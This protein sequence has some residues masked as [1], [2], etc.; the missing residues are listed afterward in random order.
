MKG[1]RDENDLPP[2]KTIAWEKSWECARCRRRLEKPGRH[3]RP[4]S[5][6]PCFE[7]LRTMETYSDQSWYA[8]DDIPWRDGRY[9][10][11]YIEGKHIDG[12]MLVFTDGQCHW[13]TLWERFVVWLGLTDAELLQWKHRPNLCKAGNFKKPFKRVQFF[14]GPDY[15]TMRDR[16]CAGVYWGKLFTTFDNKEGYELYAHH[17]RFF[18]PKLVRLE[19]R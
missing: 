11:P 9:P 18:W 8:T 14:Y 16:W 4:N 7:E 6:V 13:L 10:A 17:I 19:W 1:D 15:S 5:F 3:L 12:P 2:G